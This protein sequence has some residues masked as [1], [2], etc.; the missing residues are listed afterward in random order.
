MATKEISYPQ[1]DTE[2]GGGIPFHDSSTAHP[3]TKWTQRIAGVTSA[4][5]AISSIT[6]PSSS[7]S[8]TGDPDRG[9]ESAMGPGGRGDCGT[10]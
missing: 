1:L 10:V 3:K 6:S 4:A 2:V 5:M 8:S 9:S 7:R